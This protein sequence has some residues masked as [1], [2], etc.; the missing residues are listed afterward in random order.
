MI[1]DDYRKIY[2]YHKEFNNE[3]TIVG[4]FRHYPISYGTLET[5]K[6]GK[7]VSL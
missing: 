2:K 3:L 6:N 4:S 5:G 1:N 7:F